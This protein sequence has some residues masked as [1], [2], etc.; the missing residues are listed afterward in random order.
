MG[1][2]ILMTNNHNW[3]TCE[4]IQAYHG[5]SIIEYTFKNMKNKRHLS[6][7]PQYHWTDQKIKVHNFCCVIA[8][9]MTS[10]IYK[11]AREKGFTGS[12][13]TLLDILENIRL[14]TIIEDTGKKGRPKVFYKLEEMEPAERKLAEDLGIIKLHERPMKIKGFGVYI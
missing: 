3:S 7:T 13:D 1:Y 8:Y 12:M 14:G 4:I 11:T 9:L 5:Q 2:R 10:L 6:F